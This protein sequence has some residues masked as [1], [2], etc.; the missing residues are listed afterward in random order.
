MKKVLLPIAI[1]F[2]ISCPLW[3]T[4]SIVAVDRETG[5]VG[6]AGA[7]YTPSVWPIL[8]IAGGHGVLVAQ[9]AGNERARVKAVK[10]LLEGASAERIL[11]AITDP[12]VNRKRA[13]QQFGIVD[14]NGE[15]A[16]FTGKDCTVWAGH[17]GGDC[18]MVQG[19]ILVDEDVVGETLD[20][21]YAA[22]AGKAPLAEALIAALSAGFSAGGDKRAGNPDIAAM[23]SYVAV[24]A[25]DDLPG[26]AS[27]AL[28]VPP[29]F[30]GGNP[31]L[32][33]ERIYKTYAG[34]PHPLFFPA[35]RV[36]LL[37]FVL[38]PAGFGIAVFLVLRRILK[39]SGI[40]TLLTWAGTLVVSLVVQQIIIR[41]LIG[42]GWALPIYGYFA[43]VFPIFLSVVLILCFFV[44]F[45]IERIIGK[46]VVS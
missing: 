21:Y 8:G 46:R 11:E 18:V 27:F 5:E 24:A 36:L 33:L 44:I 16:G 40:M 1:L 23:T 43:V 20:A 22:R 45:L 13:N 14:C 2:I 12:K 38:I 25:P 37:F 6:S 29:L 34:E 3:A 32:E 39:K 42:V 26:H 4:W 19:N 31:V 9:A 30:D 7:S 15:S 35:M 28:I 41:I 10:M 17:K